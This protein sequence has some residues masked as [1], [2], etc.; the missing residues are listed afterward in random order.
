MQ[1]IDSTNMTQTQLNALDRLVEIQRENEAKREQM[2][3]RYQC[4]SNK[5]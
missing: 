4:K 2:R 1:L 5:I 3:K